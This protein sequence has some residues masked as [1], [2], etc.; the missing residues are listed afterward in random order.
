M[1]NPLLSK[2][3]KQSPMR[4]LIIDDHQMSFNQIVAVL[5]QHEHDV[6]ATLLD[7]FSSFEKQLQQPWDIIIFGRAYDLK[8]EQALSLLYTSE[9]AYVPFLLLRQAEYQAHHYQQFLTKGVYDLV[10]LS[11]LNVFYL[12]VM[13]ALAFSRLQQSQLKLSSELETVQT[14]AQFLT[15]ESRKA[16]AR[17]HEGIHMSANAEYVALFDFNH[18]N[19]VIGLPLLDVLQ[20]EDPNSF[21]ARFKKINQGQLE[22]GRFS[23]NSLNPVLAAH[24]PQTIEFTRSPTAPHDLQV[25][26]QR[27]VEAQVPAVQSAEPVL[28]QHQRLNRYLQ[29]HPAAFNAMV[30]FSL[31][32]FPNEAL[33]PQWHTPKDYLASMHAF[34][35]E[36]TH[37]AIFELDP[38]LYAGVFQAESKEK[39]ESKLIS[40]S[41][42]LKPQLLAVGQATYPLHLRIG[43]CV[44]PEVMDDAAQLQYLMDAAFRQALPQSSNERIEGNIELNLQQV[45]PS[46]DLDLLG[47]LSHSLANGQV[48]LKYQQIYDKQDTNLHSYEVTSGF[49]YENQWYE[50][51]DLHE[52]H[53]DPELSIKVDRWIL[54]EACKQ[55]HNFITQYPD[56]KLIVNLN[57]SVLLSDASFA[58]LVAKLLSIIGSKEKRSLCLQFA[59]QDLSAHFADAQ[60]QITLLQEQGVAVS[61]RH[62][63]CSVYSDSILKQV[64]L[65]GLSLHTDLTQY[66]ANES[67]TA[68][69]QQRLHEWHEIRAVDV[70]LRGLDDMTL[71]ANAWNVDARYIQGE[72]FQKKVDHLIGLD[73]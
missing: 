26:M 43:Y 54:V 66:L 48:Q 3:L 23:F 9:Q 2:K 50:L 21:K 40:L 30:L 37:A 65:N 28:Q 47:T 16:V 72:Y 8:V 17:I 64:A 35:K 36:Q 1:R 25:N 70:L 31:A 58:E 6:Q 4:L 51:N 10:D 44:L 61:L 67:K 15:Q 46:Q 11:E 29:Q 20:P 49:I 33:A 60:K 38:P 56:A 41:S 69:L 18:E 32:S 22:L 24:N 73:D 52:L 71:F 34:L 57:K 39:L 62:F 68:E 59:E 12:S 63:G 42:L 27:P 13:R 7:D 19:D 5:E 53:A 55:L 14:Q 45:E